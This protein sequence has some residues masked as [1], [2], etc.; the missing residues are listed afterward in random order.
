MS[1]TP[2]LRGPAAEKYFSCRHVLPNSINSWQSPSRYGRQV[3]YELGHLEDMPRLL[4]GS[5]QQSRRRL[6]GG[7]FAMNACQARAGQW[8]GEDSRVIA[9]V[10]VFAKSC[11]RIRWNGLC[12]IAV[13]VSRALRRSALSSLGRSG[14]GAN[15]QTQQ[16]IQPDRTQAASPPM[17]T[18]GWLIRECAATQN[19]SSKT[20]L[21]F[22]FT[23]RRK[24]G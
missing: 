22:G 4:F 18:R 2:V 8:N 23:E 13:C 15:W 1:I 10:V 11:L 12:D 17:S 9:L 16:P 3:P 14:A 7:A 24:T 21:N 20:G 5:K 19:Q 6:P